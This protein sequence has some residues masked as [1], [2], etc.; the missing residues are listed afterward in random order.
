MI[1]G[2][3][4]N[5]QEFKQ[6][7]TTITLWR[8]TVLLPPHSSLQKQGKTTVLP[9]TTPLSDVVQ[10]GVRAHFTLVWRRCTKRQK[11]GWNKFW[12]TI[13]Q[14]L[15]SLMYSTNANSITYTLISVRQKVP[16]LYFQTQFS[17]SKINR[18]FSKKNFI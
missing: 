17:M 7:K 2:A 3:G 13:M 18:F 15:R 5:W 16:K 9:P 4:E 8:T 10:R 11:M 12:R 6:C 14:K 1:R